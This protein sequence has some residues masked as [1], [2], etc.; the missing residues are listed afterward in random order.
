[1]EYNTDGYKIQPVEGQMEL[2]VYLFIISIYLEIY[3]FCL[4]K[5]KMYFQHVRTDQIYSIP[6]H[7]NEEFSPFVKY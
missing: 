2:S 7:A 5:E 1:M 6:V 4:L 3:F